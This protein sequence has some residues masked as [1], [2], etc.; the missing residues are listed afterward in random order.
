MRRSLLLVL[1]LVALAAVLLVGCGESQVGVSSNGDGRAAAQ[2]NS[3][4]Y[5]TGDG[6]E[7]T[8]IWVSGTGKVTVV[9][10]V[11]ILRLGVEA[12]AATVTEAQSDAAAAMT[13][14]MAALSGNGVADKDIQTQW[15]N[16]SPVRKWIEDS[17]EEVTVGYRVTNT[18]TAKVRDVGSA[19]VIID[20]VTAAGGDLTRVDSISFTV[21]EPSSYYD[22]AREEAVLDAIAKAEQIAAVA[23]VTLGKPV[24]IAESGGPVPPPYP[25]MSYAEGAGATTPISPGEMEISLTVQM[26]FAIQ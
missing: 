13:D 10:D 18:V 26:A 24:Y 9:P 7:Q 15:Y 17:R 22:E 12:Q 19:G 16:I 25:L 1:G 11:A 3:V 4:G 14:V 2:Q 21:D 20:A 23:D 8:G 5:A 6:S